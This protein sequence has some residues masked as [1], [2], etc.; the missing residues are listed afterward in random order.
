MRYYPLLIDFGPSP[1]GWGNLDATI[2]GNEF[3]RA[4]PTRVGKSSL[5]SYS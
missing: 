1:R 3:L 5:S 4:I 2:I